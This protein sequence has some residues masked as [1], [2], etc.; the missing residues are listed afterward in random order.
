MIT[1]SLELKPFKWRVQDGWAELIGRYPW[2]WFVTLTFV[3]DVHPESGLKSM[4]YWLSKLNR[5]LYGRRWYKKKPYGVYWVVALEYQKRGTL[6]LHLLMSGVKNARRLS[7]MDLWE[8][9][10]SNNGFARIHP[11]E[12]QIAVSKY[13]TKYVAK[14]GEIYL[15]DNLPDVTAGL[16][17]LWSVSTENET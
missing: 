7:Y 2:E 6:H 1:P 9:L 3:D 5:E 16:A 15:S 4:K 8:E 12:K 17:A 13:L 14:D 11:V 10:G